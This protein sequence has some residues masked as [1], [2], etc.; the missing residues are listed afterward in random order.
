M[1]I[2]TSTTKSLIQ[3]GIG[4]GMALS[5]FSC[6]SSPKTVSGTVSHD[7]LFPDGT[8]MQKVSLTLPGKAGPESKHFNFNGVVQ[9]KPDAIHVAGMTFLGT[10]A[11]KIDEDRKTG[12]IKIEVYVEQ[13]KKFE[14]KLK[15]Y[16]QILREILIASAKPDPRGQEN[17]GH[18][19]WLRTNG[20]GQPTEME[21]V[22]FD[23]NADFLLGNYDDNGIPN[24]F[25]ITQDT[26]SVKVQVSGYDI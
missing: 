19:K 2:K 11:F 23:K 21:T 20:K 15:G 8:Y 22:G 4:I 16:Y 26:F 7:K 12:E 1:S 17:A 6:A 10:T 5:L 18:L 24:E 13:M 9:L 14:P 25:D 3:T